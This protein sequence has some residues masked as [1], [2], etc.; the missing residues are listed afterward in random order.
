MLSK[1]KVVTRLLEEDSLQNQ[2][3]FFKQYAILNSLIKKYPDENFWSVVSFGK[4][5]KSLYYF[6]TKDGSKIL[7]KK[8]KEF[9]Y[10]P[11]FSD[12]NFELGEKFGKDITKKTKTKNLRNFLL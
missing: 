9:K 11:K 12:Q 6:K 5:I 10:K 1:K 8:Y 4:K 7:L 3:D 2:R